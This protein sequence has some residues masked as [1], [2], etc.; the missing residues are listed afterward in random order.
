MRVQLW[1]YNYDPEPQGIAPLSAMLAQGLR[2]L[3][4][5][6]LVVAAHPHYPEPTWGVRLRPY[7]ERR[8]GIPVLRLP[9]WAGRDSSLARIRQ[10][11]TFAAAQ[12]SVAPILPPTDVVI[13]VT[14][15]FPALGAAMAF[16]RSR[17]VPWVMW[18]QDIVTDGAAT[19]GEL[20]SSG[21]LLQAARSF[22]RL[23]YSSAAAVV[24]ISEAFRENLLSKGVSNDKIVRIFNPS[25]RHAESPADVA[26]LLQHPPRVLAMGNIG[27]SQGL[28]AMVDAFQA[29]DALRA[30]EAEFVIAGS[31]VAAEEVRARISDPRVQMPG[32]FYNEE[33]TPV[34][35]SATIGLVSQRPD[36]SE[37]NLPSKLM[38]YMAFG[39]PV[40]ASVS[41]D[42]ET[43]RIVRESGAGWVT[44]A[45]DP[46]QF[47]DTVA[48]VARDR[49]ALEQASQAGFRFAREQFAPSSVAARFS[50]V[51]SNAT[52]LPDSHSPSMSFVPGPRSAV[53]APQET[54]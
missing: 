40:L 5:D 44:D 45:A 15:S 47:A 32:V 49:I 48:R 20:R 43:A 19:T 42:S 38:N 23:T 26:A 3:G 27:N 39:I 8:D 4:H 7:R 14:P 9:L 6:V 22:E 28:G 11:L 46:A 53:S 34:L 31:G 30:L 54:T 35:R 50:D 25:S 18:L 51:L 37:F 16:A 1:S 24:V 12:A 29:S 21:P 52:G 33:L 13:A 2:D 17:R 41:P 36:I 10:E